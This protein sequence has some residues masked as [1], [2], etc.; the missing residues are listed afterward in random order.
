M[1]AERVYDKKR[2]RW[3]FRSVEPLLDHVL[4]PTKPRPPI[5]SLY[6]TGETNPVSGVFQWHGYVD[7]T[8]AP[9]PSEKAKRIPLTEEKTFTPISGVHKACIWRLVEYA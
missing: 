3:V 9:V 8:W 6:K 5:G 7:G 4:K 2:R 1:S